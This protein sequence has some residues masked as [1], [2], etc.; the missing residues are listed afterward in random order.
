MKILL[1]TKNL[2]QVDI[3]KQ[4]IAIISILTAMLIFSF[5]SPSPMPK[6]VLQQTKV[7]DTVN[8]ILYL[9]DG[10]LSEIKIRRDDNIPTFCNNP[11]ALRPSRIKEVNA[12]AIGKVKTPSGYF[13]YFPNAK[14]GW[15]ALEIVLREVYWDKSISHTISR[16]APSFE[17]NTSKYIHGVCLSLGVDESTLVKDVHLPSL[18]NTIASIEGWKKEKYLP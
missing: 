9:T 10:E 17:N 7:V 2:T 6:V 18:M 13:L 11:G 12:L 3:T 8:N 4:I 5:S 15:K 16:Y 1:I 14:N